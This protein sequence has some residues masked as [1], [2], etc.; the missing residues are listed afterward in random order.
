M[1]GQAFLYFQESNSEGQARRLTYLQS[2][3]IREQ[4]SQ[5]PVFA[6]VA[7]DYSAVSNAI[8]M[9]KPLCGETF[10]GRAGRDI[11]ALAQKLVPADN[12]KGLSEADTQPRR[13]KLRLFGR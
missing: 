5:M 8:N 13:G 1:N 11:G 4:S 12:T 9:G 10:E 7:N 6:T 2:D 3:V